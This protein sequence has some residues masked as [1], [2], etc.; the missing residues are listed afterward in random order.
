[1][2]RERVVL[3]QLV[4][5][6]YSHTR[7]TMM[8]SEFKR[9]VDAVTRFWLGELK[10][11]SENSR[12]KVS[13]FICPKLNKHML[14]GVLTGVVPPSL[15]PLMK[16]RF[17]ER[18][19]V[20]P[21]PI[22]DS[23]WAVPRESYKRYFLETLDIGIPIPL[24][25]AVAVGIGGMSGKN[26]TL[27]DNG[28]HA[29]A[30][31]YDIAIRAKIA[32]PSFRKSR[33]GAKALSAMHIVR[34]YPAK[35]FMLMCRFFRAFEKESLV[36]AESEK[37]I[38]QFWVD[39]PI[40]QL[41]LFVKNSVKGEPNKIGDIRVVDIVFAGALA[42]LYTACRRVNHFRKEDI[43]KRYLYISLGSTEYSDA[44]LEVLR[45]TLVEHSLKSGLSFEDI[46]S[47][48]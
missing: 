29:S 17:A 11:N 7:T 2:Y 13:Y 8:L 47:S 6:F 35:V 39:N 20:L 1:M 40:E 18:I 21:D 44:L 32:T 14:Y 43:I 19:E 5:E 41:V 45:H 24:I 12:D 9:C 38:V 10:R 37:E 42:R 48:S 23:E 30:F 28:I 33:P 4:R 36:F 27:C 31:F 26:T 15:Y 3:E 46:L 16:E 22:D 34:K 25:A